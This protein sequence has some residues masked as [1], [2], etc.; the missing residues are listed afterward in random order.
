MRLE[1]IQKK[2]MYIKTHSISIQ[3]Q[4]KK[5]FRKDNNFEKIIIKSHQTV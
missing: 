5:Q 3:R 2:S 4:F 1:N